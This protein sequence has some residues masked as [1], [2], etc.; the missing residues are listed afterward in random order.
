MA[1]RPPW[2]PKGCARVLLL[3]AAGSH[4]RPLP[5]TLLPFS[6]FKPSSAGA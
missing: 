2:F 4:R 1:A 5:N 3:E 6:A